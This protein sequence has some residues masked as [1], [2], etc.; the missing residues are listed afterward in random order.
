MKILIKNGLLVDP[1]Q[2]INKVMNIE[3]HN[4]IISNLHN[5]KNVN[6]KIFDEVVDAKGLVVAPGLVDIHVHLR[7]PGFRHKETITSGSRSCCSWW[8]YINC[9][10]AKYISC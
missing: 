6:E 9:M 10:Y 1:S 5:R 7:D 3:V 4:G 8:F 2:K